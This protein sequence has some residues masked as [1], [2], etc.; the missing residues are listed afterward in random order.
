MESIIMRRPQ[1]YLSRLRALPRRVGAV[2][3][4]V[5]VASNL[6][7][8]PPPVSAK[9]CAEFD[10]QYFTENDVFFYDPCASSCSSGGG[11]GTITEVR[12]E[13]NGEK[14]FNFWLDAGL[15]REQS[16]GVTGSMK[17][18]SGFSPFRGEEGK[19]GSVANWPNGGWG[20][21]QFTW[22][23]GQR[24]YAKTYVINAI[25]Q[26]LF[27]QYY[28]AEY[29]TAVTEANGFI[30]DGIPV[31]VND[32][33]L[34]AEL[35]YLLE[36]VKGLL[37]ATIPTRTDAYLA[38]FGKT[39][40]AD[41]N[42]F[43]HLGTLQTPAEAAV[44]WTY[45][46]E[47]PGDIK[48]TSLGRGQSADEIFALYTGGSSAGSCGPSD[49]GMTL[50]EAKEFMAIYKQ[51]D[52]G[53]PNG[54]AQYLSGACHTLTD[55]CV[56]FSAYFVN[57]YTTLNIAIDDGGKMVGALSAQNP[58]VE[59]GTVPKPYSI[60]GTRKGST[61]CDDGLPCGHTGIVLG[62]DTGTGKVIVGEAAYCNDGFTAAREYDLAEWTDG[63]Y[64]F[65]YAAG[66]LNDERKGDLK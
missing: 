14:I 23:P 3:L 49:G 11:A 29:S 16:A 35:N 2:L 55:N 25:G 64:T 47:W 5:L 45:L 65:L 54:D 18:E 31:D 21:A 36:H 7:V 53:D 22:E 43:A 13:N 46:Y 34:L 63:D 30:P 20:I 42:L 15:S 39:I 44:A 60:F 27:D 4:A 56:T 9:L 51:I 62:V 19:V 52:A 38:D 37:P 1:Q 28:K 61:I 58:G 66:N 17:H 41:E 26:E 12:G 24:S 10:E 6:F 59:V 40:G 48:N 33:F 50:D 8:M 57:K 32:K